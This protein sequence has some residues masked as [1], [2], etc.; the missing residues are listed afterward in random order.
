MKKTVVVDDDHLQLR[1]LTQQLHNLGRKQE[2]VVSCN[3]GEGAFKTL[4]EQ[5]GQVELVILDL[6]MPDIDGVELM[7][8]LADMRYDGGLILVSG[9]N[10][11]IL[12]S[13][14]KLATAHNLKA[15]G[16]LSKPCQPTRLAALLHDWQQLQ[17]VQQR[18]ASF[19]YA[20]AEIQRAIEQS[21]LV[22]FYQPK[23]RMADGELLG[24]ET[25]VRWRHPVDGLVF[26]DQFIGVAE[27][28]GLI[29]ELTKVVLAQ[30]VADASQWRAAGLQCGVAVNISMED[31]LTLDL[32]EYII[33]LMGLHAVPMS[34]LTLEV[35]ESRLLV[36]RRACLEV[37]TRLG[38]KRVGLSIDDFGTGHSSL[39]Q[40]RD[41]P[42]GELKIDRGFVHGAAADPVL[43]AIAAGSI[44]MARQ[45]N[46][47]TVAEGV[48]DLADWSWL[49]DH[50]CELAQGYFIGRPMPAAELQ[51]WRDDWQRRRAERKCE[52][53]DGGI[54]I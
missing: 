7:R 48:E 31:L 2:Q 41:L 4:Q 17:K 33:E 14:I 8:Q 37:L 38:L 29:N 49:R 6:N 50:G 22:N 42:F 21:E 54:K 51:A 5:A 11:R 52:N 39:A 19:S 45:L 27:E 35:T 34:S 10:S 44:N 26:P 40:L 28:H 43:A 47:L 46:M 12:E 24:V 1:L 23:V 53:G 16:G 32:P 36:N 3:T 9:E 30:A 13:A 25:L 15:L 20:V 18:R